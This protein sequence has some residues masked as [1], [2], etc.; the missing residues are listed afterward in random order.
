MASDQPCTQPRA[1]FICLWKG[2]INDGWR[3]Q[4]QSPEKHLHVQS[5][6]K[7]NSLSVKERELDKPLEEDTRE[8]L[9]GRRGPTVFVA[10]K[11]WRSWEGCQDGWLCC[12]ELGRSYSSPQ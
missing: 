4:G 3:S 1:E 11:Q 8:E 2:G 7:R 9:S 5:E 6:R 12:Y 10:A